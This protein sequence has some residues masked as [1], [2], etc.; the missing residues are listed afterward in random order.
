MQMFNWLVKRIIFAGVVGAL[1][2]VMPNMASA[3]TVTHHN[4][5]S[6]KAGAGGGTVSTFTIKRSPT[7]GGPYIVMG[8]VP[9][10]TPTYSDSTNLTEGTHKYYVIVATGPGGESAPSNELDLMTPFPILAPTA[11]DSLTGTSQ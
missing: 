1:A 10:A 4:D 11:P 3:Q 7:P 9:A 5:L 2:F 6:W 8:S